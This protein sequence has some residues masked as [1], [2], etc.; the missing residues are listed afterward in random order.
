MREYSTGIIR[1]TTKACLDVELTNDELLERG[2]ELAKSVS[3]RREVE[4]RLKIY[5]KDQ[6]DIIKGLSADI[7]ELTD[8]VTNGAEARDVECELCVN[9]HEG[10]LWYE[11]RGKTYSER[12]LTDHEKNKYAQTEISEAPAQQVIDGTT[13]AASH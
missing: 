10:K 2:R 3:E 5:V 11:H 9:I 13:D 12:A 1:K 8:V 4:G 6:Q 7:T